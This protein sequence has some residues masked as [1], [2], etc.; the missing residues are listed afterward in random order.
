MALGM[1]NSKNYQSDTVI[2]GLSLIPLRQVGFL[3]AFGVLVGGPVVLISFICFLKQ[4]ELNDTSIIYIS[5]MF[6]GG[7]LFLL[8]MTIPYIVYLSKELQLIKDCLCEE[9]SSN[10]TKKR[11]NK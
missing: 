3:C 7:F 9:C 11:I 1:F 4:G 2:R 5:G 10:I 8:G 6:G